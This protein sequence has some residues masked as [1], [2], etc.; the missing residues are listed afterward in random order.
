MDYSIGQLAKLCGVSV[1]TLH[2]YEKL[3]LLRPSGRSQ[4]G[5]RRYAEPDIRHLHRILA[6]KQMGIH[7]KDIE[8]YLGPNAPPLHELLSQQTTSVQAEIER[9]QRLLSTLRRL[10]AVA[11][12]DDGPSLSSQLFE[13]MNMMQ[14]IEQHF[15]AAELEELRGMRDELSPATR[16]RARGE[17]ADLIRAFVQAEASGTNPRDPEVKALAQRW[18]GLGSLISPQEQLR[19]KT[20]DLIDTQPG[21]QSATGVTPA[22]KAYIDQALGALAAVRP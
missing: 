7:L 19:A 16:K 1:R 8:P 2:H 3:G 17:I 6:Y 21:L 12:T 20:R 11:E 18:Q 13:L 14:S 9:L 22:L 10:S 5:Y 15:T 4:S